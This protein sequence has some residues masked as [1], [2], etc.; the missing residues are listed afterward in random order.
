[1]NSRFHAVLG[2]SRD[3]RPLGS[4]LPFRSDNVVL[5]LSPYPHDYSTAFAFSEIPYPPVC[6]LPSR[7]GFRLSTETDGLTT[8]R[9]NTL[10]VTWAPFS[11][12]QRNICVGGSRNPRTWLPT[13]WSRLVSTFSL[14]YLTI[15]AMVHICW[16]YHPTLAPD[17]IG[18]RSRR[19]LSRFGDHPFG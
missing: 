3:E 19:L 13:F 6:R 4:L 17:R 11:D 15:L 10:Q 12:R 14:F 7:F 1:M 9:I 18:A 16:P 5:K 2:L 8:F